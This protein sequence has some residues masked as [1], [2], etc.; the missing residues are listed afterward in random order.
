MVDIY[1][2]LLYGSFAYRH[3]ALRFD[4]PIGPA[5]RTTPAAPQ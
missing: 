4:A 5:A 3:A 1:G 2:R